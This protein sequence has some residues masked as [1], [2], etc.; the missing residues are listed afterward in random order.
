MKCFDNASQ[1][2]GDIMKTDKRTFEMQTEVN[3]FFHFLCQSIK[4]QA[5]SKV[6]LAFLSFPVRFLGEHNIGMHKGE[7]RPKSC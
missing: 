5:V 4:R 7:E 2:K 3:P 6:K 1:T